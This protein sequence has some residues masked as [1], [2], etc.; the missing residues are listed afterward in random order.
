VYNRKT[1]YLGRR[2]E[3]RS[4]SGSAENRQNYRKALEG[5]DQRTRESS[6]NESMRDIIDRWEAG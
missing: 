1:L 3:A 2:R 6:E 5:D 4:R